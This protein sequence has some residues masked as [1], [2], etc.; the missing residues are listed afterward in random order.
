MDHI[1]FGY[2]DIFPPEHMENQTS[3]NRN[4]KCVDILEAA[5]VKL[6]EKFIMNTQQSNLTQ[7]EKKENSLILKQN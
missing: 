4:V 2:G 3:A 7:L 6:P 5:G 1:I